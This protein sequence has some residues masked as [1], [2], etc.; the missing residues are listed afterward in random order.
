MLESTSDGFVIDTT[1]PDLKVEID[2][3]I[4][5]SSQDNLQPVY[6]ASPSLS[7]TLELVDTESSIAGDSAAVKIGTFP[8]GSNIKSEEPVVNSEG[9][10]FREVIQDDVDYGLPIYVTL[11][12]QNGAGVESVAVSNPLVVDT[13]PPVMGEVH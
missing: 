11:S 8:G 2:N 10:I 13:S 1:P 12:A 3:A 9:Y 6:Q 5:G 7:A 4:S